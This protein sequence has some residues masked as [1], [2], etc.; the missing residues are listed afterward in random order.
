[1]KMCDSKVK[2]EIIIYSNILLKF[3]N[4]ILLK[5]YRYLKMCPSYI[6]PY[7]SIA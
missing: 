6:R 1:M 7:K 2:Y 3:N 4:K 5:Y